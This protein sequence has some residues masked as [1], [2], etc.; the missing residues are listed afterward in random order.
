M[1]VAHPAKLHTEDSFGYF[2]SPR[3]PSLK[4]HILNTS[5]HNNVLV[6]IYENIAHNFYPGPGF[7]VSFYK[8]MTIL[9][10]TSNVRRLWVSNEREI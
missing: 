3:K 8:H 4:L 5:L 7:P 1:G 9:S 2:K 10:H 6:G